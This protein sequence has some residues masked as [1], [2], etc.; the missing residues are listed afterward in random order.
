M[1]ADTPGLDNA[2]D[3]G[4][5]DGTVLLRGRPGE[6]ASRRP[7]DG[8]GIRVHVVTMGC[9]HNHADSDLVASIYRAAGADVVDAQQANLVFINSCTV[10]TP[11]EGRAFS[12]LEDFSDAG[13]AVILAGCVPQSFCFSVVR[14]RLREV[15]QRPTVLLKGVYNR[16]FGSILV[17]ESLQLLAALGSSGRAPSASVAAE[18]AESVEGCGVMENPGAG[19]S[20]ASSLPAFDQSSTKAPGNRAQC[21]MTVSISPLRGILADPL[22]RHLPATPQWLS[23]PFVDV[24]PLCRGCLGSCTYCKTVQSR[25]RLL[26]YTEESILARIAVSLADARIREIWLTGEDTLAWGRDLQIGGTAGDFTHLLPRV[27]ALIERSDKMVRVGMTDP[28]SIIGREEALADFLLSKN[29][30]KFVHLPVQSGSDAILTAMKRQ[31]TSSSFSE[32]VSR[33]RDL[34]PGLVVDTDIICGFPGESESDHERTLELLKELQFEVLNVTQYYSR[35]GTPAAKMPGQVDGRERRRRTREVTELALSLFRRE[36][37]VGQRYTV[38]VSEEL[39]VQAHGRTHGGRTPNNLAVAIEAHEGLA[40]GVYVDVEV[41]SATRVALSARVLK[42]HEGPRL[43]C[44]LEC[45]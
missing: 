16:S 21:S 40:V 30:Y 13:K 18:T 41:T 6:A 28:D 17:E 7:P 34:V 25:G 20:S 29:V 2:S 42:I 1:P 12:L 11:S 37:Y 26:S 22:E 44:K 45:V 5:P 19:G 8:S 24:V 4:G 10:K 38:L 36:R 3:L 23:V 33:L 14:G 27:K 43:V 15:L 9:S 32:S 31:Y 35:P 39:G